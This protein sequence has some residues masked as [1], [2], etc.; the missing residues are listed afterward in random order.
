MKLF[1]YLLSL[2]FIFAFMGLFFIKNPS[3]Q[4]WLTLDDF[5]SKK[6]TVDQKINSIVETLVE[7]YEG[8]TEEQ[9]SQT[10][11]EDQVKIYRWKDSKG[12][13][14]YSDKPKLSAES[15]QVFL[16]PNNIVV[17]PP[18]KA[19][20]NKMLVSPVKKDKF[21]PS[22]LTIS[23]SKVLDLYKDAHSVQKLADDREK[24]ISQAI[25]DKSG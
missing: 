17:L 7:A 3:G 4:T 19:S 11:Q 8:F 16:E 15:E 1:V 24:N 25:K 6:V 2:L 21:L 13:W 10:E 18:L 5:T 14:S 20:P 22:P 12:H 9:T 23:P